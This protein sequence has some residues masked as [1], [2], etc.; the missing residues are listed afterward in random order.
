MLCAAVEAHLKA[1][2][3]GLFGFF[4]GHWGKDGT[5]THPI[6]TRAWIDCLG[7]MMPAALGEK[8]DVW[9]TLL[10]RGV[11]RLFWVDGVLAEH[12]HPHWGK[13]PMDEVYAAQHAQRPE[14]ERLWQATAPQRAA[15]LQRLAAAIHWAGGPP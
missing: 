10:A 14:A 4:D 12:M 6:V 2:R 11:D 7:Y 5:V 1:D 15:D 9:M 13:A 8:G 3:I